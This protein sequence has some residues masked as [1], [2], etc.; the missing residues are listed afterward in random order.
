[1]RQVNQSRIFLF[2]NSACRVHKKFSSDIQKKVILILNF[3]KS[4][5]AKKE[6]ANVC[7]YTNCSYSFLCIKRYLY[8]PRWFFSDAQHKGKIGCQNGTRVKRH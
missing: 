8:L 7:N 6:T 4:C 3:T 1:M 5:V 2:Q